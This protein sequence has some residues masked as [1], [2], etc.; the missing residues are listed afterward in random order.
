MVLLLGTLLL[1]AP[2]CVKI[3]IDYYSISCTHNLA[4]Q[5]LGSPNNVIWFPNY[6]IEGFAGLQRAVKVVLGFLRVFFSTNFA[7][8]VCHQVP[9]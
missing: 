8:V 6:H 2:L 5:V 7:V 3:A 1:L 4:L 9:Y